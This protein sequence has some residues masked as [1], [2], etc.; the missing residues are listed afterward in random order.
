MPWNIIKN[1]E[2]D[3]WNDKLKL[4]D[5]SFYQYPYFISGEYAS[6]F[7]KALFIK[8]TE[9]GADQAFCAMVEIGRY[10]LKVCVIE[11]GPV[12]LQKNADLKK[13]IKELKEFAASKKYVHLQVRP[14]NTAAE[15]LLKNDASFTTEL[16]FPFHQ[17]EEFDWNIYNKPEDELLKGFKLQCR[18]KIV[19]AGRVPYK[20]CKLQDEKE[21]KQVHTLFKKV[22]REKSYKYM[23]FGVF[24]DIFKKGKKHGLCD[25]YAAYLNGK[26]VNAIFIVKDAQSFYHFSSGMVIEG[27]N[28][29][30]SP[31]AKLHYFLMQDCFY[32]E[33]KEYYNISFGGSDNLIRFK[34]L[35]NPVEIE[36]PPY[37]TYIINKSKVALFKKFDQQ[38]TGI[39]RSGFKKIS[40]FFE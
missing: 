3:S 39:L 33:N 26:I 38:K 24:E 34:E 30:E 4:T 22:A 16:L 27:Y 12:I 32:T 15:E 37:Y 5:A 9:H 35:F 31:P 40:K 2:I 25:I 10:P 28:Y 36:K 11:C 18:R 1:Q 14:Y 13:I 29:N 8:Y 6:L 20:F 19:L 17:K 23:P 21:L 7:S